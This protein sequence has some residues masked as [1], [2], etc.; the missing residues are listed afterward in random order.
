MLMRGKPL[1]GTLLVVQY[2]NKRCPVQL[3]VSSN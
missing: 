3:Q 2:S 1:E